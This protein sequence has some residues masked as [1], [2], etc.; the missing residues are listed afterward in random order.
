MLHLKLAV[1]VSRFD[2]LPVFAPAAGAAFEG[3]VGRFEAG[4][5]DDLRAGVGA[6][7]FDLIAGEARVAAND[8]SLAGLG[9]DL[10]ESGALGVEQLERDGA[11]NGG[12]HLLHL[13]LMRGELDES[14][15]IQDDRL[16][17]LHLACA[18]AMRAIEVD[19]AL[20]G[21]ALPLAGHLDE[22]EGAHAEDAGALLVLLECVAKGAFDVALVAILPHIDEV[23]D[24][25][26]AEIAKAELAGDFFCGFQVEFVGGFLG[27][28]G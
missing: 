27:V 16:W 23:A 2:N 17:H 26:A 8:D 14:H 24:D 7:D 12:G 20:D 10:R 22:A 6:G 28:F 13:L 18:F 1:R 9:F 11:G 21:W 19:V 3:E 15:H 25:E 4:D 5:G